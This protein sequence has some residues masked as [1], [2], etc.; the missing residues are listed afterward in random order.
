MLERRDDLAPGLLLGTNVEIGDG[1]ELGFNA[2]IHDD[3]QIGADVVL[4]A[5]VVLH[6]G[7][8]IG[9]GTVIGDHA[10]VGK[11]VRLAAAS[12]ASRE[13]L[14]P[15]TIGTR[16]T[17]GAHAVI[18]AG[19]T[20]GNDTLIGDQAMLRERVT[21][22]V[23]CVLGRSA[24]VENDTT[25]GDRVKVQANAYLTAYMTLEDDVFIAPC[26]MTTN[27]NYMGRTEKRFAER[28][29]AT[30]RRAARIGGGSILLPNIEIGEEGFVGAGA[31]VTKN[32][33][34]RTLVVGS[35]ARVLREVAAEELL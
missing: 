13:P 35:P 3:V 17:I 19:T 10:V 22:G 27:D 26:V 20:I 7:T 29:G 5:G 4:G 21:V 14:P 34:P 6:A 23:S 9:A 24:L 28:G 30:I 25:L 33:P 18:N 11:Q 16:V 2:V 15:L 12:T 8:R 1:A 31:I 32:V